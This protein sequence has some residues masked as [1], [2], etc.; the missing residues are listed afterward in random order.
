MVASSYIDVYRCYTKPVNLARYHGTA[1]E[2]PESVAFQGAGTNDTP[3]GL[4]SHACADLTQ[5]FSSGMGSPSAS[6]I[7]SDNIVSFH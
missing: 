3:D 7:S 2:S 6:M 5:G 4:P 1:A